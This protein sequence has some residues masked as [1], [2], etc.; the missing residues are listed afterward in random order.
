MCLWQGTGEIILLNLEDIV[1][2][3]LKCKIP[4]LNRAAASN[5]INHAT[6]DDSPQAFN[7]LLANDTTAEVLLAGVAA[8]GAA[9]GAADV[10]QNGQIL[11]IMIDMCGLLGDFVTTQ[12]VLNSNI[13][14]LSVKV[15]EVEQSQEELKTAVMQSQEDIKNNTSLAMEVAQ[16]AK[17]AAKQKKLKKALEESEKEITERFNQ[18]LQAR[19]AKTN[20]RKTKNDAHLASID[21]QLKTCRRFWSWRQ[22]RWL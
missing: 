12:S 20:K 11:G 1:T 9:C 17:H 19:Y 8:G 7:N 3:L 13:A 16:A 18:A 4:G 22:F 2:M 5:L 21:K 15:N 14:N 6:C 10:M